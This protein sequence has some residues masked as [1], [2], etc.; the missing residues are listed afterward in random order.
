VRSQGRNENR[1]SG[2]LTLTEGSIALLSR[3]TLLAQLAAALVMGLPRPLRADVPTTW[4]GL[5]KGMESLSGE[6]DYASVYLEMDDLGTA[7]PTSSEIALA[8]RIM[9]A[10]PNNVAPYKVAQYLVDVGLGVHGV[11]LA[12][13]ARGWP[14]KYNPLIVEL[15]RATKTD[16][17]SRD[18]AG[19]ATPW[20]AAFVNWC[21]A[22]GLSKN[23]SISAEDL[24]KCTQNASSGSFRCWETDVTSDPRTGDIVV[25]AQEGPE[26]HCEKGRLQVG[27]GHVAF[28]EKWDGDDLVVLGGNQRDP[29]TNQHA[30]TRRA[31]PRT[32]T[33]R[34]G[35]RTVNVSLHSIRTAAFLR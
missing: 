33:R 17:L 19:D 18:L 1:N 35:R 16:P 7:K 22:R 26:S 31:L 14:V 29:E 13:Y 3:R 32:F 6:P 12:P 23:G 11:D 2:S 20:C 25:W 21:I 4:P 27:K 8:R 30:V 15:F 24:A 28:F 9:N 34:I 5:P 10:A